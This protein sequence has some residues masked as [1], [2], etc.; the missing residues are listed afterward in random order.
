MVI[1]KCFFWFDLQ[2]DDPECCRIPH[3]SEVGMY[4]CSVLATKTCLSLFWHPELY[5]FFFKKTFHY[6]F[7]NFLPLSKYSIDI[8]VAFSYYFSVYFVDNL[9]DVCNCMALVAFV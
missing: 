3:Q 9:E 5:L 4:K 2:Q 1:F 6:F 7:A 8:F